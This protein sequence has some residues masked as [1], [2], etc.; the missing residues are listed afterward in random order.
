MDNLLK[1]MQQGM[2]NANIGSDKAFVEGVENL[3][4]WLP[5]KD[6]PDYEV[7]NYGQI[8]SWKPLRNN[9]PLP[10]EPRLLSLHPDKDGYLK[11][12]L[13]TEEGRHDLRVHILVCKTFNRPPKEN[14]TIVRHLNGVNTDNRNI[15]LDWGTHK[16]NS[17]D[18]K[19]HGTYVHGERVNTNKLSENEVV[20]IR[21]STLSVK[22]LA[23]NYSISEPLV[24]KIKAREIWKHLK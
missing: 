7:S 19:N 5:L 1:A 15:N 24:Y 8:R 9:S 21:N 23:K 13:Y 4:I 12:I 20:E 16:D 6:F 17:N 3:Q 14:E 10:T 2:Q 11:T 22:E 18:S